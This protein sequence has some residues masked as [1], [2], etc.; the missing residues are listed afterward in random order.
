M[1]PTDPLPRLG[2]RISLRRLAPAD[3]APFQA[4]RHN[5][6][7]WLYQGWVPQTDEEAAQFIAEM[8]IAT[9]FV[10][11]VWVQLGIA[12]RQNNALIGDI[13][14]CLSEDGK[15]AEIGFTLDPQ[16]QGAGLASE[17]VREAIS[18]LF[19]ITTAEQIHGITDAR[20]T[21][22]IKLLERLG[23][24]RVAT[25]DA[26]FRGQPC[27]EHTYSICRPPFRSDWS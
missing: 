8:H 11:G 2:P 6:Q 24:Q 3:L 23:M 18:L 14:I 25:A 27:I 10:P 1:N 13:G 17:A 12:E 22:S 26:V 16:V 15:S 7:A 19:E 5:P 4:Y 20:N 21:A 9:L